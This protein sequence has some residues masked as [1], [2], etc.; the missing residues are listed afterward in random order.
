MNKKVGWLAVVALVLSGCGLFRKKGGPEMPVSASTEALARVY[1]RQYAPLA[2]K[3][4]QRSGVP[5]SI[6]LAQ[7][8]LESDYGRSKL[9]RRGN[10]HFGIKCKTDWQGRKIYI[11][12]DRPG[13]CFRRYPSVEASYRD[14]S[15]FL[16]NNPRYRFLFLLDPTDY[17]GWA[18]GLKK[19]G[20]ATNPR[21]PRLLIDMIERYQLDRYDAVG[22]RRMSWKALEE[23]TRENRREKGS[24][25]SPIQ[26]K[27]PPPEGW[28]VRSGHA[29]PPGVFLH[30][31]IPAV[32]TRKGDTK[33]SIA[34]RYQ[35]KPSQLLRYND[36]PAS[37]DSFVPGVVLYLKP[38]KRKATKEFHTVNSGETLHWISQMYGVKLSALRKYNHIPEGMEPLPGEKLCLRTKC[39]RPPRWFDPRQLRQPRADRRPSLPKEKPAAPP[40]PVSDTVIHHVVK[41]GETLYR[42]A[43]H[44][45]TTVARI[46]ELNRLSPESTIHPGDTLK[47]EPHS[48]LKEVRKTSVGTDATAPAGEVFYEVKPGDTFY[49]IARK[50]SLPVDT[51]K[52]L[53]PDIDPNTIRPGMKIRIQ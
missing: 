16:K 36:L 44:Y 39:A 29:L 27:T 7:G 43:T 3:E 32:R 30:N 33:W 15:D 4:M 1:I 10:N 31:G 41:P 52:K 28:A 42:I 35:L 24:G 51:L 45:Q 17:K 19:A 47:V 46:Q 40:P 53:N 50:V 26:A 12:D 2:V 20:Y 8:I 18:Y 6:T 5:A 49:G 23:K 13:E 9:A 38:K 25:E 22:L 48:I 21:Y 11:D 34:M 14:H 37:V